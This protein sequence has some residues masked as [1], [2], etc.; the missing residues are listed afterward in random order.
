MFMEIME[1]EIEGSR[2]EI[3]GQ[4]IMDDFNGGLWE[5]F[6]SYDTL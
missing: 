2:W 5:F 4:F 6:A 3:E 1:R